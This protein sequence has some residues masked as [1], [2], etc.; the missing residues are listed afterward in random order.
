MRSSV[1]KEWMTRV[2]REVA[3]MKSL[4]H[5]NLVRLYAFID[6]PAR[7]ELYLVM[8][9]VDGGSLGRCV[10]ERVDFIAGSSDFEDVRVRLH[11][12]PDPGGIGCI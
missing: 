4:E 7:N 12:F 6:D 9:Y 11:S 5:P 2:L 1:R 10:A 3:V 8:E